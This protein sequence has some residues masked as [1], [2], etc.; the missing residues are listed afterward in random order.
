MRHL[1]RRIIVGIVA[2]GSVFLAEVVAM[3]LY[4]FDIYE[5]PPHLPTI[6]TAS[7]AI[8][9]VVLSYLTAWLYRQNKSLKLKRADFH[10]IY[11]L[12][13]NSFGRT[14]YA[15]N[16]R[17]RLFKNAV[18]CE[19][20]NL[21]IQ[22]H[23]KLVE[24]NKKRGATT[25]ELK[26]RPK[27]VQVPYGINI[28]LSLFNISEN[29][30]YYQ[31]EQM[32]KFYGY[33]MKYLLELIE[34]KEYL[35]RLHA[36]FE[37]GIFF[38][39]FLAKDEA[40]ADSLIRK[41]ESDIYTIHDR[42]DLHVNMYPSFG[43]YVIDGKVKDV[44]KMIQNSV[45]ALRTASST[46]QTYVYYDETLEASVVHNDVLEQEIRRGIKNH[47]FVVYYQ[48]KFDLASQKFVGAEA[49]IRW[50]HPT[51]GLYSPGAFIG[52]C[53]KSGLVHVLDFYVFEQVC[54]DLG[55]WKRRGRRM[56]PVSVNFSASDF[57]HPN[58]VESIVGE[59][60]KNNITP[61][62]IE[63]EI[64][65]SS[66]ANNF[67]YVMD[68]LRK[69]QDHQI[70]ILMDDFGVGFS[71]LGNLAKYPISSLKI[72]KSFIDNINSDIKD[73]E[74]VRTII[75]LAKSLG[76]ESVAEGVQSQEQVDTL[77]DMNCNVIQGFYYSAPLSKKDFE[78]FLSM[79]SFEKKGVLL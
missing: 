36:G 43:F 79:N 45:L 67:I 32:N 7:M 8:M 48:P 78:V 35:H 70:R 19:Q 58:F 26:L 1:E 56:I 3:L 46:F 24:L 9:L 11:G 37:N 4:W 21:A 34:Q 29:Y 75:G 55:D 6:L 25:P 16:V 49:L 33:V 68:I 38:L 40:E 12:D 73:R 10:R 57:Y 39:S 77:K 31:L 72:D 30:Q 22:G 14:E 59:I 47:E 76:M 65:E 69:L 66:A 18:L 50:Q 54:K 63:V 74:I 42:T 20:R 52:E 64:T 13:D 61:N 28:A 62:Y 15:E 23:E 71:S 27:L 51:K 44:Y 41:I 2:V 5:F 17:K 60:E 53:E